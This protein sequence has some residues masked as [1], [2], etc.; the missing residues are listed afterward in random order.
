[1][2]DILIVEDEPALGKTLKMSLT[3]DGHQVHWAPSAEAASTWLP[4][5]HC[6][7]ALVDLR[8][9]KRDGLDL[10][11]EITSDYPDTTTVMM[12]AHGDV[13][14]AVQ[15]MKLGA[16]DFLL[17]PVD[18]EAVSIVASRNI[19]QGRINR[20]WKRALAQNVIE[21][22]LD[23]II[24]DCAKIKA[25][26]TVVQRLSKIA[27]TSSRVAPNILITGETGTGKDLFA[28]AIHVEGPRR[29]GA[30]VHVNCAALPESLAESELFGHV[31]GAFTDARS[32]KRGL[33]SLADGGTLFLDEV[34]SLPLTIQAKLLTAIERACIRAVGGS[35]EK[36][37]D[38]HLVAAMNREPQSLIEQGSLRADLYHRLRVL[39][40]NLP[41]LRDRGR[42]LDRLAEHFIR[43]HSAELGVA[44]RKLTASAKTAIR[45]YR[46]PGNIR[47]LSHCLETAVLLSDGDIDETLIAR[48]QCRTTTETTSKQAK[49]IG[50]DNGNG[51]PI[52]AIDFSNGPLALESI[53]REILQ[54]AMV[55]SRHNIAKAADM[56]VVSRDTMRYRLDKYGLHPNKI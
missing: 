28:R 4:G 43:R 23:Q 8:L 56:L 2:S 42:D 50:G 16:A 20:N 37:V 18:L 27:A 41:P 47:E 6:D 17:K 48:P 5:R 25:A 51:N 36:S 32:D 35:E 31:K 30:F 22:G 19:R 46:W 26:K 9:P 40:I 49:V 39:E 29:D 7:L 14:T 33:F 45:S 11:R 38:V 54:Q 34:C 10:L 1:V 13:R 52:L 15:A 12:T 21:H 3:D 55:A 44:T 24:G 53:E